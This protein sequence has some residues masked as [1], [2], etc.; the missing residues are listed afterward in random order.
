M[1]VIPDRKDTDV[2][3]MLALA[4]PRDA[5]PAERLDRMRAAVHDAWTESV[6]ELQEQTPLRRTRLFFWTLVATAAG[7]FAAIPAVYFY[8][9]VT[10]R[11]KRFANEMDDFSMEF[12]TI[13]ERNFT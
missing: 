6:P 3:R 9:D 2:E 8:N 1:S 5:V 10:S 4:G 11:V 7:L 12:L 13:A